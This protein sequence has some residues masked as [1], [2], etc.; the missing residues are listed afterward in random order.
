MKQCSKAIVNVAGFTL[1]ELVITIVILGIISATAAPKFFNY[2]LYQQKLFFDDTL[3]AIRYAQKLAVVTAC[4]VNVTIS[5]NQFTLLRPA[6][7]T[8]CTSTTSSDFTLNVTRPGSGESVYQG[9]LSGVSLTSSSIF[10][11][12]KGTAS[13]NLT[14]LVGNQQIIIVQDTGFVY[15]P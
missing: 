14:L 13:A 8:H 4:N 2:T 9:S 1:I 11:T 6:D 15:A 3:N 5:N 10:F 12:A 7:R